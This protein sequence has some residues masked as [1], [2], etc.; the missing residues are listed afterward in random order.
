MFTM[1]YKIKLF[2]S[3]I[4]VLSFLVAQIGGV[5]TAYALQNLVPISG[6]VQSI[7]LEAD[8]VTGVTIVSIDIIDNNQVL[9][10][11]RISQETA[12][13]LGLVV[14]NEDG[15]PAINSSALGKQVEIEPAA[16]IPSHEQNQHPVGSALATFFSDIPGIDYKTIMSAHNQGVGFGV[17]AQ[18]LWLTT[19]LEGNAEVFEA[20]IDAKETGDYSA[21]ILED[22]SSPENW[23]QLKKAILEK[24]NGVGV[25]MSGTTHDDHGNGQDNHENGT[26]NGNNNGNENGQGN[27]GG[28]GNGNNNGNGGGNGNGG[29]GGGN[30]KDKDKDNGNDKKK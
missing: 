9:Q 19:K 17:I 23:G 15:K 27:G 28:N 14:L 6:L 16:I 4:L 3:L 2:L 1:N 8:T 5:S 30:D 10:S 12:I 11:I 13:T 22:G 18:T 29:N 25:V 24:K 26:G 20:L 21:F 7:T